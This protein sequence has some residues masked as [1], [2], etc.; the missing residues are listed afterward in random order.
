MTQL[1]S[2]A[3]ES[4][5]DHGGRTHA[6]PRSRLTRRRRVLLGVGIAAALLAIGGLIGASFVKS[7]QQLAADTAPPPPTATTAKVVSQVL[8]SSVQMRGLVYPSTEYDVYASAPEAGSSS[9]SSAGSSS[10]GAPSS[11]GSE[12]VYITK[13]DVATGSTIRNGEQLAELDGE[14]LFALTGSVP[15]WRDLLPGESGPDVTELQKALT[16]LGYYYGGDIPGYYGSAT[17]DA[18]ALYYEHLG[19]TP[20]STG[21][22][23]MTDVVFLASLPATVVAVNGAAG[24]QAGQPFLELAPRG[25]LALTG[26]LPPAYAGQVKTGLKVLIYD[27]VT[28]IHATGTVASVEPATT[29]T[30]IGTVVDVGSGASS[31]G[32]A[33]SGSAG[34]TATGS[35]STGSSGSSGSS[36]AAPFVPLTVR[37]SKPL[38]T[39]LN[40]E[41]VLVTVETGQTEGPVLTVPVAAVVS[42]ASGR[43]YVTVVGAAGKQVDV[44]VTP[45]ISENGYV[46]VTPAASGSLAAGDHVVVSG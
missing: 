37:P 42:T 13:L 36:G 43:S 8:T 7:P 23:P 46:E 11:T 28:G 10:S 4:D 32:S 38:A 3:T 25:S 14:P 29:T 5:H 39:A 18:V 15:A 44:A 21:G 31:A 22:V 40:G 35:G 26:E 27:E 45:G 1:G 17:E 6:V 24:D 19:Y 9:S 30:P 16:S 33:S 20:P 34:S 12:P 2:P 41:N